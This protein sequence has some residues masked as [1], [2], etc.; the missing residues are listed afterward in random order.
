[1]GNQYGI[2]DWA[3]E[4]P[5]WLPSIEAYRTPE[6]EWETFA[7]QQQPFWSTRA[8]LQDVGERMRAKYLLAAPA[9][10]AAGM[11]PTFSQYLQNPARALGQTP[12]SGPSWLASSY[13]SPIAELRR[14]AQQAATAATMDP[15]AYIGGS[16]T[17]P[18]V[19]GSAEF[20]RRAW[21]GGQFGLGAQGAQANQMRVANLLALQRGGGQGAY[22]GTMAYAIRNAMNRLAGQYTRGI[23]GGAAQPRE[24]FLNWYLQRTAANSPGGV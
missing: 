20:N 13:D 21:M 6:E 8:P 2:T 10:G 19:P 7:S 24:S 18:V 17:D 11:Q 1:M 16:P 5:G 9:M 12:T 22:T 4:R 14:R 3:G 23:G 15:G